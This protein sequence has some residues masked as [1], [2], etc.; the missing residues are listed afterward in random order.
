[1]KIAIGLPH[2][3]NQYD[4]RFGDA[5]IA[6]MA[7]SLNE[8][9]DLF[10]IST[11]RDNITFARNKIAS[12]ALEQNADYLLF[13]DDDMVFKPDLLVN[14]LKH[15]KDIVGGL[16]FLRTEP[17]EPSFYMRNSDGETFNPIYMWKPKD[18]VKC[19]AIGMAA[20]LI[21]K[22]VFEK[23]YES[24]KKKFNVWGFFEGYAEDLNFCSKATMLGFDVFCDTS[25]LVG[26]ITTK[27]IMY[28][29]YKA[30]SEDKI[31][32]IKKMQAKK[33]YENSIR[34]DK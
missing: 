1:M 23:M 19:D 9:L 21:K 4:A 29:D 11:F 5:L 15:D 33:E 12:K 34:K 2:L 24:S 16:T 32:S 6:L 31:L 3:N 18:L 30:I 20:T 13:L 26:H 14:L 17:H 27:I 22:S 7:Y 10:P 28:E 25:Q 8:G